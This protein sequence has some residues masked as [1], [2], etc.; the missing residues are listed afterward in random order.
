MK[1]SLFFQA[2]GIIGL[3]AVFAVGMFSINNRAVYFQMNMIGKLYGE[4]SVSSQ[5]YVYAIFEEISKENVAVAEDVILKYGFTEVGPF[6]MEKAM[7]LLEYHIFYLLLE[8]IFLGM[9]FYGRWREKVEWKQEK[10]LLLEKIEK[11]ES[12]RLQN[13]FQDMQNKRMQNFIENI[14]H[15]IKTP[16]SRIS[17]SLYIVKEEMEDTKLK[18]RIEECDSHL[19][20]INRLMKRLIDIGRLEA[21]KIIYKK[22]KIQWEELFLDVA[23]CSGADADRIKISLSSSGDGVYYGDYEWLKE[24]FLNIVKNGLEHDKT[25]SPMEINCVKNE[26]G[27]KV[28]IRDC[29]E[30]IS[31]KDI[32]NL[33]DRFYMPEKKK[34]NHT[35]IGLNLS[36]LIFEGHFGT[37]YVYN[38]V[39][40]GAVFNVILPTYTL[41]P[42]SR[43]Y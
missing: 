18:G 23:K 6:H 13:D 4:E 27:Y 21:G 5:E 43:S 35:G 33:F 38:H 29:G 11:L 9:F 31:E 36:K 12:M 10:E 8:F 41:K 2:I 34:E 1:N 25:N 37:V 19:D 16:I 40:G 20:N 39:E 30:G 17:S 28:T 22:E 32:P 14:A 24:A 42:G 26:N 7:G 3:I 15:Q